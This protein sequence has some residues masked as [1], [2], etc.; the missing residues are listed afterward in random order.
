MGLVLKDVKKSYGE[1]TVVDNISLEMNK[2]RC[3]WL[4]SE[5]TVLEKLLQ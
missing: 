3:I 4:A 2:P 5:Q 1:K